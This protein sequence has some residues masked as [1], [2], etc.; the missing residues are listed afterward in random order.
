[1]SARPYGRI[2]ASAGLFT[3]LGLGGL[4]L[5]LAVCPLLW[6]LPA[7]RRQ[8]GARTLIRRCF[9]LFV[10]GLEASRILLVH[11]EDLPD[12]EARRG[13]I[14]IANHPS[15][16]DIV[17]LLS[18]LPDTVCVV[19]SAVWWNPFFG[20]LVRTAGF[21]PAEDTEAL[22]DQ[23]AR[24]L[25]TGHAV[26][27][28]PEGTRTAPGEPLRFQRGAAHLALLTGAPI[29]PLL[30]TVAPPLLE[31]GD[32]WYDMPIQV[33][34]FRIRGRQSISLPMA[35]PEGPERVQ[36]ARQATEMLETFYNREFHGPQHQHA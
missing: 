21:L 1:M 18:R 20:L 5:S 15:W 32:R 4:L 29:H 22:L 8:T 6:L 36:R 27:L 12:A 3:C 11:T 23:A 13:A 34:Q 17:V 24:T 25:A 10:W 14:L 19:K 16:L 31:K 28:F 30:I 35:P 7:R 33:C 2:L 9:Q 26:V